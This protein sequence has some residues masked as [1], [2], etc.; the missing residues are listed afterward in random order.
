MLMG[1]ILIHTIGIKLI[2]STK[3][4]QNAGSDPLWS[5]SGKK[6]TKS[7]WIKSPQIRAKIVN[8]E[9]HAEGARTTLQ[10]MRGPGISMLSTQNP[11]L[12]YLKWYVNG[13]TL[14]LSVN[15]VN[16]KKKDD[17]LLFITHQLACK[18][19]TQPTV[20]WPPLSAAIYIFMHS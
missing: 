9:H 15:G 7:V 5:L 18:W 19:V 13:L 14:S 12:S 4:G 17:I 2:W 8:N 6:L 1:L 16:D 11:L 10:V 3:F 20:L